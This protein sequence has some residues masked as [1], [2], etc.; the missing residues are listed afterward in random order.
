MTVS[1]PNPKRGFLAR[2]ARVALL[3]GGL[4]AL[5]GAAEGLTLG[6]VVF[7]TQGD[8]SHFLL[9]AADRAIQFGVAG[10]VLGA[11]GGAV[12]AAL[13]LRKPRAALA[14]G[15]PSPSAGAGKG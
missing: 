2:V 7:G 9:L 13:Q 3:I 8:N 6:F 10:V 14:A 11:L 15:S 5:A 4:G 1:Q 12:A